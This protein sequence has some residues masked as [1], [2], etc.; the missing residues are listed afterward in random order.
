MRCAGKQ[1]SKIC[2][3]RRTS[4][5]PQN[6]NTQNK[7]GKRKQ[8]SGFKNKINNL[9]VWFKTKPNNQKDGFNHISKRQLTPL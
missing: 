8:R 7:V 3:N 6:A 2:S 4:Q 9:N 1:N 5:C